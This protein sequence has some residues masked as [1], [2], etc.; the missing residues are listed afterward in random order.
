MK[1]TNINLR[2]II[3]IVNG[4]TPSNKPVGYAKD[5]H[6][7]FLVAFVATYPP[8]HEKAGEPVWSDDGERVKLNWKPSRR[9]DG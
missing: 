6:G 9:Q 1:S 8:E 2:T 7:Q 5:V 4:D 3:N